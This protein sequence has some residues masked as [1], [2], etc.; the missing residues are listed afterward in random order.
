MLKEPFEGPLS[1]VSVL[2]RSG[3]PSEEAM[4]ELGLSVSV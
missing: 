3:F 4:P 1:A 2:T